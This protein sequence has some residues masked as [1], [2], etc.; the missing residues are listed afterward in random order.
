MLDYAA[1]ARGRREGAAD[2]FGVPPR[3]F[4]PLRRRLPRY[5]LSARRFEKLMDSSTNNRTSLDVL[6]YAVTVFL[7]AFLLFEIEPL[8]G[9]FLLPWFGGAPAV[10]TTCLLFFQVLLLAGYAYAHFLA[11]GPGSGT[12]TKLHL[13]FLAASVGLLA[14]LGHLW[15]TPITPDAAWRPAAAGSP[16]WQMLVLL[17]VSIGLPFFLLAST[18]PLLQSWFGRR[19]PGASPYRLY[20]LSNLGSLLSLLAYPS[21]IEW[22]LTL[23]RQAWTWSGA[24]VVFAFGCG[25]CAL[26]AQPA[27]ERGSVPHTS[28]PATVSAATPADPP[29]PKLGDRLLW[30]ALAACA[31]TLLLA[32]T[33]QVCQG[34]AAVPFLWVLPL[35]LYLL[36]F[37]ICFQNA[38]WYVRGVFQTALGVSTVVV[39]FALFQ[40]GDRRVLLQIVVY[41]LFLFAACM[42]CHGELVRLKPPARYL[43]GFYLTVAAGGALG[44]IFVSLLAPVLFHGY[45][46]FHLGLWTTALMLFV[47]VGRERESWLYQSPTWVPMLLVVT[48]ALLPVAIALA[49]VGNRLPRDWRIWLMGLIA[50]TLIAKVTY[51][52]RRQGARGASPRWAM[53][54]VGG[55]LLMLA[56]VLLI[57]ARQ[58]SIEATRNF[59]GVLSVTESDAN[60]PEWPAYMLRHGGVLHGSQFYEASKRRLPT[61]YYGRRS[62]IGLVLQY[63]PKRGAPEPQARNLRVG[64]VGLG[65]GTIVAYGQPGDYYRFYEINPEVYRLATSRYFT[66]LRDTPARV[67]VILGDARLSMEEE[68]ER[69][70]PQQFDVLVLDAFAGDAIP[71]HLLT[72]EAFQIYLQHLR[73]PDGILAV[74]ISNWYLNLRPVVW[75][76]AQHFRL[77]AAWLHAPR[78]G[79]VANPSDWM[80]VAR[81]RAVLDVPEIAAAI[82]GERP[83]GP[84]IRLWTD[85][86]SNLFQVLMK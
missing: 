8:I 50:V 60:E 49:L 45:W 74:H 80:L 54:C 65:V 29:R 23:R 81:N 44:G 16:S 71:V 34:I 78:E 22:A 83:S 3:A 57:H 41:M 6:P 43:T 28:G 52:T 7:S 59:Y 33:N 62:A 32:T 72:E 24:Y 79:R 53:S 12:R 58:P 56:V 75:K 85:D 46:E 19:N 20:A 2:L 76:V 40:V 21:L 10:W 37:I 31:S 84:D 77:Q 39:C 68:L 35:S 11:R 38:R 15:K 69:H 14:W 36:S 25:Y 51:R 64:A 26:Q 1:S 5:T 9:K 47:V 73:D 63:H 70:D 82:T 86:Y 18:S 27:A 48:A 30:L 55:I 42:V 61:A 67:D 13:L 17:T 4:S 66:Y